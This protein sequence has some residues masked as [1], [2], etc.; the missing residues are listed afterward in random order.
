MS[1]YVI[2]PKF[3]GEN[4]HY[5]A[6]TMF[7]EAMNHNEA[8]NIAEN[9]ALA[10]FPGWTFHVNIYNPKLKSGKV[11]AKKKEINPNSF[12]QQGKKITGHQNSRPLRRALKRLSCKGRNETGSH[13]KAGSMKMW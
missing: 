12:S 1:Q 10:R 7:V 13:H 9:S 11:I 4:T 6:P 5:E 3:K 2:I 8:N